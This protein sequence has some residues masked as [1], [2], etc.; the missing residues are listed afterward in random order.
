[1]KVVTGLFLGL[2]SLLLATCGDTENNRL[3]VGNWEAAEWMINGQPSAE[4][5]RNTSFTFTDKHTYS[6]RNSGVEES[7]T[8]KVENDMLFT[9]PKGEQEIMVRIAKLTD[10]SLVFNMNR[11]G[12]PEVLTLTRKR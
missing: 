10:D 8:Y 2:I 11:G 12:R 7:G 9:T 5:A 6:F 3:I 1:M 4:N